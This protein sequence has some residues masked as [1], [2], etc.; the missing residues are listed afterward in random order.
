MRLL[1]WLLVLVGIVV[2]AGG[3]GLAYLFAKYPDVPAAEN[4]TVQATPEKI[5]RGE[6]LSKHVTGCVECHARVDPT[7]FAHPV[8][9]ETRGAGGED[10]GDPATAVRVLYSKNITPAAIGSWTDGELI[11]AFTVGVS[12]TGDALFP[13]MPYPRYARLS[14]EDVEAIV[15]YVRTLK[16]IKY[17]PPPRDL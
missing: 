8:I 10:F 3:A 12:N 16:P 1:K 2:A 17:T 7:K 4:I 9:E 13:I 15:A 14:R 6:Y 5:A 11:R